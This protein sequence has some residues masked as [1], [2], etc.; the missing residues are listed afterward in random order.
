MLGNFGDTNVT[1]IRAPTTVL[2]ATIT[3]STRNCVTVTNLSDKSKVEVPSVT[4]S[5]PDEIVYSEYLAALTTRNFPELLSKVL[6][7][8]ST[9]NPEVKASFI[10]S[11]TKIAFFSTAFLYSALL[12]LCVKE[13][14]QEITE[15]NMTLNSARYR[16]V[17]IKVKALLLI[18][19][20]S[21]QF[22]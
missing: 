6:L 3:G 18:F 10:C 4:T 1:V 21:V 12:L 11:E 5:F 17:S 7:A 13:I 22:G 19:D 9:L 2:G 8:E 16:I 14:P 15:K 20:K